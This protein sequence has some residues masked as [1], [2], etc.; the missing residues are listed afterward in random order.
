MKG[1]LKTN[2]MIME[3]AFLL[4]VVGGSILVYH[5]FASSC[6]NSLKARMVREAFQDIREIDL[7]GLD[8]E[9]QQVLES[10]EEESFSFTIADEDL[11]PVYVTN[12]QDSEHMVQKNIRLHLEEFEQNPQVIQTS[13]RN[14]ERSRL[15]GILTQDGI[16]YYVCIKEA[17]NGMSSALFYTERFLLLVVAVTLLLG[18]FVMYILGRRIAKPIEK[19]AVVSKKLAEHDFS[20]RVKEE[21]P[22]TEVNEL[23]RNFNAMADQI[24]YYIQELEKRNTELECSN[25]HLREQNERTEGLERMRQELN[26]NISH[27]LKT[28]LAIIASQ[29][30]ML[31]L[32]E[33][34]RPEKSSYYFSSIQEE[35]QKMADMIQD[36]LKISETGHEL[37]RLEWRE[38][39]LSEITE[40]L[41]LKYDALFR[42]KRIKRICRM[43]Q[44]C[45]ILADQSSIEKAIS[46]YML[47]AFR[48]AAA[49]EKIMITVE[50]Q[51]DQVY[52]RVYN[53]GAGIRQ[54][55]MDHIWESYYQGENQ[56]N[57]A[58]LGLYIVKTIVLLHGGKYGA[59]N[60][61]KGVEFWFSLPA[62]EE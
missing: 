31:E 41:I 20:A 36:L 34:S 37:E 59:A 21:T 12:A 52:F 55:D 17:N 57:H 47:N 26:A 48:H 28:P 49:G 54:E 7:S 46:N 6:Y 50:R 30:E 3:L 33:G 10:Y 27:E 25:A 43:E 2:L 51:G 35:I 40:Y 15:R 32:L 24:Q 38:L 39:D 61:E 22:Y 60:K 4:I 53:D 16:D 44:G 45:R 23:A 1:K 11:Q 8:E 58:G 56:E 9:D 29:L 5:L 13:S 19:L 14:T 42:Q 18:S 62:C